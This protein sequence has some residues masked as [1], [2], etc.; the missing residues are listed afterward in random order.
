M[1]PSSWYH[2]S[3]FFPAGAGFFF[4]AKKVSTLCPFID[5]QLL[6]AVKNKYPVPLINAAFEPIHHATIFS[7][8]DLRNAYHL[9]R[10]QKGDEWKM[11]F[12][13]CL[14]HFEYLIMPCDLTN[15]LA[16]FQALVNDVLRDF[17][18]RTV[19]IYLDDILVFSHDPDEQVQHMRQV[20]QRLWENHLFV[21]AEK[22]KF[23]VNSAIPGLHH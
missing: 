23:H 6:S 22:C 19:F 17:L 20:L 18:N 1:T 7:K 13:T 4:V 16:A 8:L 12:N 3:I 15:A 2:T 9:V 10:I 14:G 11:A 5:Y 21:K